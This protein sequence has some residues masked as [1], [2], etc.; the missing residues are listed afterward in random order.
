[1]LTSALRLF[2]IFLALAIAAVPARAERT[3]RVNG[4]FKVYDEAL[5]A[6]AIHDDQRS[7]L[8]TIIERRQPASGPIKK[9]LVLYPRKSTAYDVAM[10]RIL[11]VFAEKNANVRLVAENFENRPELADDIMRRAEAEKFDLIFAMG[12]EATAY[13]YGAHRNSRVP[14]VTVCS[15]DPVQLG[16][17]K[18]YESGS[19]INFAFTSLNVLVE[20]QLAYLKELR[21]NL[22]NI[23]ILVDDKNVSAIETQARPIAEAAAKEGI[24]A[25]DVTVTDPAMPKEQLAALVPAAVARMRRTD[26]D[27][28]DSIFW[29]TGSTSVF[30]EMATINAHADKVPVLSVVPEVVQE[31]ADSAVLSI[32][33]SFE[34]N[35]HLAAI[36]GADILAGKAEASR[37]K[38]GVVSPPDIAI[39]FLRAREIGLKIPFRFFEA[40]AYVYDYAGKIVRNRGQSVKK[41]GDI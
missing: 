12:S 38:V 39:N 14:V 2:A 17:M 11:S 34:S 15:K 5:D 6:W 41:V 40:A 36:Y 37:L 31:G 8:R 26:P 9:V 21:P 35:A 20:V 4:W 1:M 24:A 28:K 10:T 23:A 33:V 7:D 22:K 19:G 32:G 30:L 3:Q 29:V 25:F 27:L 13:L 18:D 16:Q